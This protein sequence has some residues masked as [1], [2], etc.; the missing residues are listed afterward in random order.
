MG[1]SVVKIRLYTHFYIFLR[2]IFYYNFSIHGIAYIQ[3]HQD[4]IGFPEDGAS[5][6]PKHVG[7][8]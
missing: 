4:Y 8:R 3:F 7:A 6:A 1:I 5:D 2:C